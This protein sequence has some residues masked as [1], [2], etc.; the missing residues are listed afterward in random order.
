MKV[1]E[2]VEG[3]WHYHLSESGKSDQP[4]LCGKL[5]VMS[6]EIPLSVWG[7]KG[8][9]NETYC[10][11]CEKIW[12]NGSKDKRHQ[13][14]IKRLLEKQEE[15]IKKNGWL[16]HYVSDDPTAP[17]R[18]NYH[19]H[20]LPALT[21]HKDLQASVPLPY[22][23]LHHIMTGI[24]KKIQAG[25][26][27]SEGDKLFDIIEKYPITFINAKEG[28]RDVLRVIFPDQT[29]CLDTAEMKGPLAKQYD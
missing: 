20:G 27:F 4:A 11:E 24:V 3:I 8:H 5:N 6:T 16:A 10:E 29:G 14:G 2:G 19:T 26:K 12:K 22:E 1:V 23:M 25:E 21:G 13:D 9:L 7:K 15:M 18:I 17:F 28:E